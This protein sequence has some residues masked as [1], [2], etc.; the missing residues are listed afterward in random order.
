MLSSADAGTSSNYS[1]TRL[2]VERVLLV[3]YVR[4]KRYDSY[5]FYNHRIQK[6]GA[7]SVLMKRNGGTRRIQF[8]SVEQLF[9]K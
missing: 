3:E 4:H 6:Q 8:F 9:A 7:C 5:A 1:K 2:E